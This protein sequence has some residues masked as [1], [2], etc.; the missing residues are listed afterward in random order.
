MSKMIKS[1]KSPS[2]YPIFIAFGLTVAVLLVHSPGLALESGDSGPI[3]ALCVPEVYAEMPAG[4]SLQ[5]PAEYIDRMTRMGIDLPARPIPVSAPS[6]DL[7]QLDYHYAKVSS[8][9]V[10]L[11]ASLSDASTG[12]QPISHLESGFTYISY[13]DTAEVNG[14]LYFL[15]RSGEWLTGGN[16]SRIGAVS[17]FQGVHIYAPL[18]RPFGWVLTPVETKRSP[19]YEN[20]E[21]LTG[22]WLSRYEMIQVYSQEVVGDT[23]WYLIGPDEWVDQRM[24]GLVHPGGTPPEGVTT[25]RWIEIN[26]FEQT[27][28]VYENSK[29]IFATLTS[30]GV[31][32][33][34]TRPGL[35]Q[36]YVKLEATPMR[37]AFEPDRSDFYNL[38]DVPWT[39]YFDDSRALHG[40]Y[41]HN[42]FGYQLSHGCV[43]LSPGD[44]HWL[45]DWAQEGDW[46]YVWDPSGET[47][48]DPDA[49]GNGG[50]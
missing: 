6:P 45:F 31:S 24:T 16:L 32:G 20:M 35:F 21:D 17:P 38:Q 19:G 18:E 28:S 36:V 11:Y 22:H 5:G 9:S 46:V 29:L 47:P 41:W 8:E 12:G 15:L 30:T 14:H 27:V 3:K 4:C 49:Y 10:P 37:G 42:G 25:G 40:A 7:V 39:M 44:A 50:A 2:R 23:T 34:W 13:Q 1:I 43:N 26:L 33:F 48:V